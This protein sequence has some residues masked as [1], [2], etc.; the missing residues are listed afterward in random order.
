M[1]TITYSYEGR[2]IAL[3]FDDDERDE[4]QESFDYLQRAGIEFVMEVK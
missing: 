3:G 4:L 2:D 1:T